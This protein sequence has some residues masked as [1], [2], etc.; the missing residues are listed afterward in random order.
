MPAHQN[1]TRAQPLP[2]HQNLVR[3]LLLSLDQSLTVE[4]N[5]PFTRLTKVLWVKVQPGFTDIREFILHITHTIK[6]N[7][8]HHHNIHQT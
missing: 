7:M 3:A 1:P 2:A 5:P 4:Q 6:H 8:L